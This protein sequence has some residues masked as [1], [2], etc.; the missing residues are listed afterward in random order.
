MQSGVSFVSSMKLLTHRQQCIADMNR[1]RNPCIADGPGWEARL[2]TR[3][4]GLP[5]QEANVVTAQGTNFI[6]VCSYANRRL[7]PHVRATM[8]QNIAYNDEDKS[9]I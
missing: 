4:L 1:P 6:N 2:E 7:F 5:V 9:R 3:N 8:Q